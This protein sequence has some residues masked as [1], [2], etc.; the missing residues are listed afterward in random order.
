MSR[1]HIVQHLINILGVEEVPFDEASLWAIAEGAQGSMRDALSLTDQAIAFGEGVLRE[2]EVASMLGTVDLK[3]VIKLVHAL[4][5]KN[6]DQLMALVAEIDEHTPDYQA[7]MTEMMSTLHRVAIAQ[8]APNA[9]DNN[10]GDKAAIVQLAGAAYAEDV[11]LYYQ[12]AA[13]AKPEMSFAPSERAGFEMALLRMLAFSQTPAVDVAQL[14][15]LN[16]EPLAEG[17]ATSPKLEAVDE[18]KVLVESASELPTVEAAAEQSKQSEPENRENISV[19]IPMAVASENIQNTTIEETVV[20][21]SDAADKGFKTEPSTNNDL[22][23]DPPPWESNVIDEAD[24]A[25]ETPQADLEADVEKS[26]KTSPQINSDEPKSAEPVIA[27]SKP[28]APEVL[29]ASSKD[30]SDEG[31]MPSEAVWPEVSLE[32]DPVFWW[33]VTLHKLGLAGMTKTLFANSQWVGFDGKNIQLTISP[34]YKKIMNDSHQERLLKS[35]PTWLPGCEK[36]TFEFGP[37]EKT[38][39]LWVDKLVQKANNQ[40]YQ[41]LKEDPFIMALMKDYEGELEKE[42]AVP[43]HNPIPSGA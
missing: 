32:N 37:V 35:I 27:P 3:R 16:S 42:T 6:I 2:Q 38:P 4:F 14:P 40:A 5:E 39:Q 28:K 18:P 21:N 31:E 29:H 20:H 19:E 43:N 8:A 17:V 33:Q 9:I 12:I 30:A 1:E 24:F 15:E 10:K 26:K 22:N 23:N 36:L 11:H 34:N 25:E 7:L 41:Y 13:K